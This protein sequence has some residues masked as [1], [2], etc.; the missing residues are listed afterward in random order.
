MSHIN[1][2]QFV[3]G[4]AILEGTYFLKE[5]QIDT[6]KTGSQYLHGILSDN[7]GSIEFRHWNYNHDADYV[8]TGSA[9]TVTASVTEYAGKT[10]IILTSIHPVNPGVNLDGILPK[11]PIDVKE[12]KK[13]LIT[14]L[15]KVTDEDYQKLITWFLENKGKI[16]EKAPAAKSVHHAF[17]NGLLMHTTN[18]LRM[19]DTACDI[20]PILDKDLLLTAAF[21]HDIG[22]PTME[23]EINELGLVEQYTME[24]NLLGHLIGGTFLIKDLCFEL[25]IPKDKTDKLLHCILSHHGQPE[26]GAAVRPAI[27]EADMMSKLDMMD[28]TMEIFR[29]TLDKMQDNTISA[30]VATLDRRRICKV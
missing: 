30:P 1:I 10:Y 4:A 23:F 13:T 9:V 3:K 29:T 21:L 18:I 25:D 16:I 11:A 5:S 6:S 22:K 17:L 24:G 19:A 15:N 20:Y 12:Y 7:S 8:K 2:A 27:P 28:A 14:I 26:Y